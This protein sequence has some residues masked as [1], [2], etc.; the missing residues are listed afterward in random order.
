MP[1][2]FRSDL[3]DGGHMRFLLLLGALIWAAEAPA[4]QPSR[5]ELTFEIVFGS[6]KLGEGHDVLEHDGTRYSVISVSEP[7]GLAALFINDIRR[8]STGQVTAS[9]LK[10]ERF[11]ESGRKGGTRLAQFD[12]AN[13][14]LTLQSDGNTE[15][16]KLPPNTYDQA[17]LPYGFLFVPP[18]N[19]GFEV[20]VTDGRRLGHYRYRLVAQEKIKTGLGELDTLHFEKVRDPDDKRGFEFWVAVERQYLPVRL[21]YS[22]RN[23][24]VFDSIITSI[25]IQ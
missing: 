9:G 18:A 2:S 25:K 17:C 15:T 8:E 7:Q 16:V 19:D 21:R 1:L 5:I 12:W 4:A 14:Q 20:H 23:N 24:R 10:P 11:E 3:P 6:M 13:G 22:D